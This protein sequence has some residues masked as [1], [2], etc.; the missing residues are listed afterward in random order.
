MNIFQDGV[1]LYK[2]GKYSEAVEK[3]HSVVRADRNNHKAWNALGVV[4]SKISDLDQS[5]ICFE[6][7]LS[8]M[9]GN[10][11]YIKNL[12]KAKSKKISNKPFIP[13]QQITFIPASQVVAT[14][15]EPV[16]GTVSPP[17]TIGN[18]VS[19][20]ATFTEKPSTKT[21]LAQ[22]Y[23]ARALS[24]FGQASFHEEPGLM[25]EALEYAERAINLDPD[26]YEAWQLKVSI[27]SELSKQEPLHLQEALI[28][29]NRSLT[30]NPEQA[31]MWFSKAG[32]L[33][34]LGKYEEAVAAYDRAYTYSSD[35]PMRKG[36]I[37]MKK[38]SAL[39]AA[40]KD[41]LAFQTYEQVPV[42]DRFFGDA[43][44]KKAGYLEKTGD[45]AGAISSIR[46]AGNSFLKQEQFNRAIDSFRFL[47]SLK[48]DDEEATYNIGVA[49]FSLYEKTQEKNYLE[50][51]LVYFDSVLARNPEN[52]TYLIQKG[53]CLL[54]MGRFD[55]G[56][57][58][59][60]RALWINP[61]DGITL[62]NK[63]I[64]LYQLSRHEEALRYF[65]LV[66]SHYPEHS[67]PWLMK[68]RIHLEG[69]QLDLALDEINQAIKLS[70][71]ESRSWEQKA[72]ILRTL[73]RE[74]EAQ[75]AEEKAQEEL[76]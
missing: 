38:G 52:I 72:V 46:T 75:I 31:S 68:S 20:S 56:L 37:L 29:S 40:G 4:L 57:Q 2:E 9:P 24:L 74:E 51:A 33:E 44:E 22:E 8:L 35:E 76:E 55:E 25:K 28:A 60:D 66:I 62:M 42:T 67:A 26:Y 71:E 47:L 11:T 32:I 27:H 15:F 59:L 50:D 70:P 14:D 48:Q 13:A 58:Y 5:I 53:R 34:R 7:A 30:L 39:E 10:E 54:D 17:Q 63:G 23:V 1:R 43:M 16:S 21:E 73:G 69:K 18:R 49:S 45:H 19:E 65:D 61:S 6:N 36:I 12:E 41:D 64:A 3:L